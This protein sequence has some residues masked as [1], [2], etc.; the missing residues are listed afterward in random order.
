MARDE[1][2]ELFSEQV[3]AMEEDDRKLVV[4]CG[5]EGLPYKEVAERLALSADAV[6][7]RWQRLRAKLN[8]SALP[9]M[10]LAPE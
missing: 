8:A 4:H 10:L 1:S 9:A 6:A 3:R 7:K 2:L 5:L